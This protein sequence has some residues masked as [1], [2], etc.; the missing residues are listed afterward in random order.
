[1]QQVIL[2][3]FPPQKDAQGNID[4]EKSSAVNRILSI[5]T[6]LSKSDENTS[7]LGQY[8]WIFRM[9]TQLHTLSGLVNLAQNADISYR[10]AF[11]EDLEWIDYGFKD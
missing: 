6:D 7:L 11:V 8:T 1:M 10:V 5:S 9:D 4:H 2:Q 3:K